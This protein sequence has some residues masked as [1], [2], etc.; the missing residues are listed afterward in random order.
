[1]PVQKL[2][3]NQ[4]IQRL[5]YCREMLR[6]KN[7]DPNFFEKI[8][9]T[10]EATFT[11]AGI[12]NRK[13]THTWA[14]E[15]PHCNREIPRQGRTS[16]NV[17]CGILRNKIVGPLFYEGAL[18]G[19]R[20]LHFLE[21]QIENKLEDL[22]LID[23][24]NL[25]WHQDGAPPHRTRAVRNYLNNRFD[26][27]IGN[28]GNIQWASNSP[29]LTPLD[30]FL[31]G[32]LKNEVYKETSVNLDELRHKVD[33]CIQNLNEFNSHFILNA[34]LKINEDYTKCINNN[35][36]HIEHL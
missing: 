36:G 12:Y 6:L 26:L 4:K 5:E 7:G 14:N 3:Q 23:Y 16:L 2:T 24:T 10:D 31:W 9:W 22:P 28:G 25:I 20:Y 11:T 27:W 13:N 1:M 18:T 30:S 35:G 33:Q 29:D 15:N 34:V 19:E 17:W 8:L 32:Y 21:N